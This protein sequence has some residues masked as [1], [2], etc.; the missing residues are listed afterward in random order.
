MM[1]RPDQ[2]IRR[3]IVTWEGLY[4]DHPNDKGNWIGP[5]LVGTMRGVTGETLAAHRGIPPEAVTPEMMKGVTLDEAVE[6]GV[7]RFYHG[8]LGIDTL[9]WGPTTAILLDWAWGS[10]AYA[11]KGVQRIVGAYPDG[12]IGPATREAYCKWIADKGWEAA[13]R[14][15]VDAR[16]SFYLAISQPGTPNAVFRE[17]WLN[18]CKWQSTENPE[19]WATWR[20]DLPPRP[21]PQTTPGLP[22]PSAVPAPPKPASQST[23]LKGAALAVAG[24]A[25]TGIDKATGGQ[26]TEIVSN[27]TAKVAGWASIGGAVMWLVIGLTIAGAGW[28]IWRVTQDRK[29][30]A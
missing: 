20:E 26:I 19:W 13:T 21:D 14:E 27:T 3:A 9:P 25:V 17:G 12:V 23:T 11:V 1:P 7:D 22:K 2:E 28:A 5:R 18:R 24:T 6:I 16:R 29:A 10:F 15:I 4:S 8:V 30:P